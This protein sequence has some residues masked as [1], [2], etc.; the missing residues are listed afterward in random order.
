QDM[1]KT[2]NTHWETIITIPKQD[3][4]IHNYTK[5]EFVVKPP[6]SFWGDT[7]KNCH[8][9]NYRID[10][11]YKTKF[12]KWNIIE[13]DDSFE[14]EIFA[15]RELPSI[16]HLGKIYNNTFYKW[17]EVQDIKLN[18]DD[19]SEKSIWKT[20]LTLPK[21]SG[22][23]HLAFAVKNET[24][25]P[26]WDNNEGNNYIVDLTRKHYATQALDVGVGSSAAVSTGA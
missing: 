4:Q 22:L 2:N 19:S 25:E 15:Q 20:K 3:M 14:I 16:I 18:V 9:K 23:T 5:I 17:E 13:Q 11:N 10:L 7:T 24:G 26:E 12:P 21:N 1:K 6:Q 8:G